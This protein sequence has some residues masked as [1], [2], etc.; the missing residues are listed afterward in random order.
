MNRK[1]NIKYAILINGML[2]GG[3]ERIIFTLLKKLITEVDIQLICLQK[4]QELNLDI[5]DLKIT[6]LSEMAGAESGIIKTLMLPVWAWRLAKY[7]KENQIDLVQSHLYRSNYVNLIAKKFNKNYKAEIFLHSPPQQYLDKGI[8]GK[9]NIALCKKLFPFADRFLTNSRGMKKAV[10]DFFQLNRNIGVYYN[11]F[12]IH[13]IEEKA[14]EPINDSFYKSATR[15]IISVGRLCKSKRQIDI[16]QAFHSIQSQVDDIE[17]IFLGDGDQKKGLEEYVRINNLTDKV[18]FPGTVLNPF[19]YLKNSYISVFASESESFGN[20]L[21]EAMA[22]GVPVISADCD[23]GPR[24]ILSSKKDRE[25]LIT[26]FELAE[27]GILYA[28]S[29]VT[30]LAEAM[31]RLLKDKN[32]Y[33][34]YQIQSRR[35]CM[36]FDINKKKS[37]S[38]HYFETT[39]ELQ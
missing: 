10:I 34:S 15:Y 1:P 18:H 20:V 30:A 4:K 11:Q 33:N 3:A 21:V 36:E 8:L 39:E 38:Q 24:E 5:P 32:L 28:V 7:I 31:Q 22:C 37:F 9:I 19:K 2:I 23:F 26:G 12:N 17:L 13:E 16:L 27:Y 6:Y 35:R 29:E 14:T 25:K